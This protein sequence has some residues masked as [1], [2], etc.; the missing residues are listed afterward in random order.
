MADELFRH[1]RKQEKERVLVDVFLE[2][3]PKE[4]YGRQ[5]FWIVLRFCKHV[6]DQFNRIKNRGACVDSVIWLASLYDRP[7][8]L[9]KC[10]HIYLILQ[11]KMLPNTDAHQ[12]DHTKEVNYLGK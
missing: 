5:S 3:R 10:R 12:E 6:F 7:N 8:Y 11:F 2:H 1:S 9:N 4:L